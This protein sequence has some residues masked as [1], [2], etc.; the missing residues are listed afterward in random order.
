MCRAEP[1]H[2]PNSGASSAPLLSAEY[3]YS[4]QGRSMLIFMYMHMHDVY[5]CLINDLQYR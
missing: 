3:Y 5:V 2:D 1:V 4:V